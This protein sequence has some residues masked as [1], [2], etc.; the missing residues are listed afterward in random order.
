LLLVMLFVLQCACAS[1]S[2]PLS[3]VHSNVTS[4]HNP[5]RNSLSDREM[6]LYDL[7]LERFSSVSQRGGSTRFEFSFRDLRMDQLTY[8]QNDLGIPILEG[9]RLSTDCVRKMNDLASFSEDS[10]SRVYYALIADNPYALYWFDESVGFH[11]SNSFVVDSEMVD[12]E[13]VACYFVHGRPASLEDTAVVLSASVSADYSNSRPEEIEFLDGTIKRFFLSVDPQKAVQA[14]KAADYAKT[15]VEKNR[16]KSDY[17]KLLAYKN[18]I[19]AFTEYDPQAETRAFGCSSQLISVFDDDPA[20][21]TIC[22]GYARA[23][24]YLC[25][26]SSFSSDR[27]SCKLVVGYCD[28]ALASGLHSWNLI[29]MDD[30]KQYLVDVTACDSFGYPDQLF[31]K[32]ATETSGSLEEGNLTYSFSCTTQ[33]D[34]SEVSYTFLPVYYSM[35]SFSDWLI[36]SSDD[37]QPIIAQT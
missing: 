14:G 19:L 9:D 11:L 8:T 6:L 30:G 33:G 12:G 22:G 21:Y 15:I 25:D 16:D 23:F 35:K 1:T 4:D 3:S 27:V 28:H 31:L 7:L 13:P 10:F 34:P 17:E 32:G 5:V 36:L 29:T 18:A 20:T 24:Q 37:Y 2:L 26:I